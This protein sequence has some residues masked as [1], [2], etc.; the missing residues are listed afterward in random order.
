M[1]S[2]GI[3]IIEIDRIAAVL[4]RRGER[5]LRRVFTAAEIARYRNRIPELA[6]RFAGKE[7]V[8]KAL[9]TGM[10]GVAWREIEILS[11][12]RGKPLVHLHGRA[13][14]RAQEIGLLEFEISLTHS[15]DFALAV[16]VASSNKGGSSA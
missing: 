8:S 2:T 13:R 10:R 12:L 7:A 14:A 4:A 5:F 11:D 3:D 16:V 1:H 6:A 15:Q 9:G